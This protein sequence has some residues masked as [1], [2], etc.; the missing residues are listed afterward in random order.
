MPNGVQE[1]IDVAYEVIDYLGIKRCEINIQEPY[2]CI[3]NSLEYCLGFDGVSNQTI[4]NIPP[5]LR[6]TTLYA[7]SQS[8]NG[9]VVNTCN[10]SE[11][12]VGYSTLYGDSAGDFSPLGN[13]TVTEVKSIGRYLG[14]PDKFI[15]KVPSDGLCGK[16]DED[17]LG[18]SYDVLDKYIRE[19]IVPDMEIKE[20]IDKKHKQNLFK[21]RPM[22][23]FVYIC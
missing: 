7:V 23:R 1:D 10:Y 12:Y 15:D 17:S 18:F 5:R 2:N 6:M 11:D 8:V 4:I 9:R 20:L 21:M 14:I 16:S 3:L 19:G 13:F 22:S